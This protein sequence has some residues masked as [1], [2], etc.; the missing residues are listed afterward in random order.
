MPNENIYIDESSG[1]VTVNMD[2]ILTKTVMRDDENIRVQTTGH[3]YDFIATVEN[4]TEK[5]I[6]RVPRKSG[7]Y[8]HTLDKDCLIV[9]GWVEIPR[10]LFWEVVPSKFG[11]CEK[12]KYLSFDR[13]QMDVTI[14]HLRSIGIKPVINTYKPQF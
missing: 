9:D 3:D 2:V 11:I 5:T 13:K 6:V 1:K 8:Y 4:K 7:E 14:D 10:E 12:T